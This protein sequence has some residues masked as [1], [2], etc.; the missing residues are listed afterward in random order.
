[1]RQVRQNWNVGKA[2]PLSIA[3]CLRYGNIGNEHPPWPMH[4]EAAGSFYDGTEI[5]VRVVTT[6]NIAY[7]QR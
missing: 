4:K 1:M 3:P 5:P 6:W 2:L 7:Q